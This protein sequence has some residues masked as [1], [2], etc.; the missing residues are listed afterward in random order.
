MPMHNGL[1]CNI[2]SDPDLN[3]DFETCGTN[4]CNKKY[5]FMLLGPNLAI[6]A[7]RATDNVLCTV[8]YNVLPTQRD[9]T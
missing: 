7:F 1:L 9:M 4:T 3:T 2:W 5:Y 6:I 8:M